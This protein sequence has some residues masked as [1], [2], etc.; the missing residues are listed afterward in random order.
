MISTTEGLKNKI[1]GGSIIMARQTIESDI[2][3]WKPASWFKIWFYILV[4]VSFKDTK[5]FKRGQGLFTYDEIARQ[6][7]ATTTIVYKCLKYLK[8]DHMIDN[9]KTTRGSLI[10]VLNYDLYQDYNIYKT[11]RETIGKTRQRPNADQTGVDTIYNNGNNDNNVI[12]S[13]DITKSAYG[14]SDINEVISYFKTTLGLPIIDGSIK[15]N[16]IYANLCIKKFGGVN[17]V[18]LLI[19]SAKISQ[20]WATKTTSFMKLY[21]NGVNILSSN[22]NQKGG[23]LRL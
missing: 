15:Q 19:D 18:K 8:R 5:Q 3:F 17:K 16:R 12:I 13:K 6:T 2:F 10:T 11:K 22:R 20:F 21:Y 4:K 7:K 1:I 14:N 23:V 9:K